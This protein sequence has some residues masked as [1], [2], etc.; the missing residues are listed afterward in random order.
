[1]NAEVLHVEFEY[2]MVRSLEYCEMQAIFWIEL[3]RIET[4]KLDQFVLFDA[5]NR[6]RRSTLTWLWGRISELFQPDSTIS[7][8]CSLGH[9]GLHR[10]YPGRFHPWRADP[11]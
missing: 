3:I 5:R 11:C 8:R 10:V 2:T 1:M 9:Q 4:K 6:M 7:H